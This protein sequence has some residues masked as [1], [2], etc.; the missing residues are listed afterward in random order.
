MIDLHPKSMARVLL[1]LGFSW[2]NPPMHDVEEDDEH[3]WCVFLTV[4]F[5]L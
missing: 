2:S 3:R 5:A 4:D 1:C